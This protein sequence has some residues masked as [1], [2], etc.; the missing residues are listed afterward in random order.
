MYNNQPV[1]SIIIV[2][3]NNPHIL[4]NTITTIKEKIK[5]ATFEIIV[6]D[7]A[8]TEDNVKLIKQKFPD[9]GLI[10]NTQNMGFAFACNQGARVSDG[11]YLL[12]V[13]SDI[14][15]NNDPLPDI[16][17]T[18]KL[19]TKVGIIGC[20]LLNE[21]GSIQTS[22]YSNPTLIKRFLDL[23]GLKKIFIKIRPDIL[24][25]KYTK[26]DIIKGAFLFVKK[27][28]F[29]ELSGFDENYFMY[30]EDVDL[31]Y[32]SQKRGMYNYLVNTES[33]VHLGWHPM[34]IDNSFAFFNGNIGLLYFYKKNKN[35]F[36]LSL[37]LIISITLFLIKY[38]VYKSDDEKKL[39]LGNLLKSYI[40]KYKKPIAVNDWKL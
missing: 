36:I 29:F 17:Q 38:I 16:L 30:V 23:S 25:S 39:I 22:H 28:Y 15:F 27:N 21:D 24:V 32:R 10:Q 2:S 19:F 7:N 40:G 4:L 5:S 35:K 1:V 12:F 31:S 18:Y 11:E 8:S 9:I 14:L 20:R 34:S 13:N 6:I 33:I 3:Y 37:F 26:V